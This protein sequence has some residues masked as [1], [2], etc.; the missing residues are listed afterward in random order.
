MPIQGDVRIN[1]SNGNI[2][3]RTALPIPPGKKVSDM[4]AVTMH[5]YRR[6]TPITGAKCG[7]IF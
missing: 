4:P 6:Q 1:I 5:G 3:K 7:K 2:A